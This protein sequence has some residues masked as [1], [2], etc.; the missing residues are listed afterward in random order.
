MALDVLLTFVGSLIV[1][2][3]IVLALAL[4]IHLVLSL[5]DRRKRQAFEEDSS[6]RASDSDQA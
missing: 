3:L 6:A 1:P 4:F 2:I 5:Y